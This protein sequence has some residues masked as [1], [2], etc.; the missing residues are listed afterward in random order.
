[1]CRRAYPPIKALF[2]TKSKICRLGRA[3]GALAAPVPY[4]PVPG[5][6]IYHVSVDHYAVMTA[7]H[8]LA[9]PLPCW[10]LRIRPC[11]FTTLT[12]PAHLG[13]EPHA[14]AAVGAG[15]GIR[16]TPLHHHW[17]SRI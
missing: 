15:E 11:V 1:V 13:P 9:G 2:V 7:E 6:A 16:R 17:D 14:P 4:Q 10:P 8:D 12:A 3:S 5:I